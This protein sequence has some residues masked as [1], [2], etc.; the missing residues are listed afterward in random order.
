MRRA[1]GWLGISYE[2]WQRHFAGDPHVLGRTI[3]VDAGSGPIMAVLAP[4][5]DLFETGSA[6]V[7]SIQ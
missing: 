7:F 2:F 1:K 3:F 6:D 4:Q 5:V